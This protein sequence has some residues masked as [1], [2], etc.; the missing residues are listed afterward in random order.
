MR[1]DVKVGIAIGAIILIVAVSYY[2][3]KNDDQIPVTA[4]AKKPAGQTEVINE[5]FGESNPPSAAKSARTGQPVEGELAQR[6]GSPVGSSNTPAAQG[7][8]PQLPG[9]RSANTNE[10]QQ[11]PASSGVKPSDTDRSPL[12]TIAGTTQPAVKSSAG[13][14]KQ[15]PAVNPAVIPAQSAPA[16]E[17]ALPNRKGSQPGQE[18]SRNTTSAQPPATSQP[19]APKP[20][21]TRTYK[22]AAGDTL[23]ELAEKYYGSQAQVPLLLNANPGLDPRR[24]KIGQEIQIPPAPAAVGKQMTP[25][26]I[27]TPKSPA[28]ATERTTT[29][30]KTDSAK[31]YTV[32]SGDSLYSIAQKMLGS[33]PRWKELYELNRTLIGSE[34]TKLKVG[35]VLKLPE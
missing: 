12:E 24:L 10:V 32:V 25:A 16:R 18:S 13:A 35:Q 8:L 15:Q 29:P 5:L 21:P 22:I 6:S 4:N 7:S 3:G 34:P 27:T 14:G 2:G 33:G 19:A 30:V 11:P 31:Q 1:T 20:N 26:P 23:A 9:K 17:N 28:A